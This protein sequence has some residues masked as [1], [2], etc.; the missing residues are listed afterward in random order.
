M[1]FLLLAFIIGTFAIGTEKFT[2]VGLIPNIADYFQISLGQASQLVTYYVFGITISGPIFA[3]LLRNVNKK[4]ALVSLMIAFVIGNF[5]IFI[6]PSY[7]IVLFGRIITSFAHAPFIGIA[8]AVVTE[9]S[10]EK[11]K[12]SR[13]GL[14][15]IGM[16]IANIVS[17]PIGTII[18][19]RY[20]W[21]ITFQILTAIGVLSLITLYF[22]LKDVKLPM[23]RQAVEKLTL[24][25]EIKQI[26]K[27]SSILLTFCITIT[28][29]ISL[30]LCFT[31]LKVILMDVTG[32]S[33]EITGYSLSLFGI[34]STAGIIGAKLYNVKLSLFGRAPSNLYWPLIAIAM[35]ICTA[36]LLHSF[37][38]IVFIALICVFLLGFCSFVMVPFMQSR[39]VEKSIGLSSFSSVL[40]VASFNLGSGIGS[41]IAGF[42]LNRGFSLIDIPLF[43]LASG[44]FG[45]I[46]TI[47]SMILDERQDS[48]I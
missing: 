7:N 6:A 47:Y 42:L 44:L 14:V 8:S 46:A 21:Q 4:I 19:D 37:S 9:L 28:N 41:M 23:K 31:Y 43:A 27:R 2:I 45:I 29:F 20:G 1:I 16:T 26:Y 34:G 10:E 15:F 39:T 38:E 18:G 40:H 17:I 12:S 36:I 48:K 25:E 5:I 24:L 32:L 22:S 33:K 13:I 11:K 30:Y 3:I 35:M